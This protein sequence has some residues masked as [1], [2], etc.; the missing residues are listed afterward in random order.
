M[1]HS[2]LTQGSV[3][4]RLVELAAPFLLANLLNL[5]VLAADRIWIGQVGTSALAGLGLAHAALMICF[6]L[7]LGPAIGTLGGV[8]RHTGAGRRER[9]E[10]VCGQ[11]VLI[12]IGVGII[13]AI[14]A[15]FLP[16][17]IL[18][19]MGSQANVSADTQAAESSSMASDACRAASSALWK[20]V[21]Y[22]TVACNSAA[23]GGAAGAS[24][25]GPGATIWNFCPACKH[26]GIVT[27]GWW[28]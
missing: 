10:K 27:C 11:G 7:I 2:S 5:A 20:T 28:W 26:A 25:V 17:A 6:T 23:G 21:E 16:T 24:A 9:A 22:A 15:T 8:A 19:F 14:S 4:R 3:I 18:S 13:F 1:G 12:S